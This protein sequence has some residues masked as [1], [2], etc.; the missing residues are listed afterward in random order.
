MPSGRWTSGTTRASHSRPAASIRCGLTTRTAPA[1]TPT[2]GFTRWTC[3]RLGSESASRPDRTPAHV[4]GRYPGESRGIA[5][6]PPSSSAGLR[7]RP[8]S[9]RLRAETQGADS[10][11]TGLSDGS[12]AG[13]EPAAVAVPRSEGSSA[14]DA[15]T[16]PT[17]LLPECL[18]RK[19]LSVGE[20]SV[21]PQLLHRE[22][23]GGLSEGGVEE[24]AERLT[25]GR[26]GSK[27]DG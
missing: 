2:A 20:D 1:T 12:P 9:G 6:A 21:G 15:A 18:W 5:T 4:A 13:T 23:H 25:C 26:L 27:R 14:G 16:F 22:T 3:T 11:I 7:H 19:A 24:H 17:G 8:P 10:R